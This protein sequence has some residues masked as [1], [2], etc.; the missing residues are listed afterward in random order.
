LEEATKAHIRVNHGAGRLHINGGTSPGTLVEG[1]FGGGLD[2]NARHK[3]DLLDVSMKVPSFIF[4]DMPWFWGGGGLDWTFTITDEVPISL[5]LSTGASESR[6]DLSKL[7]AS[8]VKLQT[9]AS[10][11]AIF[12][13]ENAGYT[14]VRVEAGAASV[15]ITIPSGVAARIRNRT[16]LSSLIVD[17][18]RFRRSGDVYQSEDYATA[19]TK[20]DLDIQAGIGSIDIR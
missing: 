10:S 5:S 14:S 20:A 11:M 3:G 18:V 12:L 2:F 16:G 1:D 8:E 4:P 19:Q 13:P 15:Q 6:V 17:R 9:G 7:K